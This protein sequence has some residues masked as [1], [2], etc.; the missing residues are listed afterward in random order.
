MDVMMVM[1]RYQCPRKDCEVG[2]AH[3]VGV[4]GF[5]AIRVC[6]FEIRRLVE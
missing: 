4:S 2:I 3:A 6:M 1:Y 5:N